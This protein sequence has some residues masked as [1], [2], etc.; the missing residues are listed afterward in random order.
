MV[1]KINEEEISCLNLY[2]KS[3]IIQK[4][5]STNAKKQAGEELRKISKQETLKEELGLYKCKF[6]EIIR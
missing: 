1:F 6:I 5:L 2:K 3:E 4:R